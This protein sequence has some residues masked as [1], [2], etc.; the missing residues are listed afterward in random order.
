MKLIHS[1]DIWVLLWTRANE[2]HPNQHV[3]FWISGY[4]ALGLFLSL[5]AFLGIW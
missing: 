4:A 2:Q 3:W 1:E 5:I